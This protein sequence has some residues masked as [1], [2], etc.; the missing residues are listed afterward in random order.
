MFTPSPAPL[1]L[2]LWRDCVSAGGA[3]RVAARSA[4][5]RH[6]PSQRE[7]GKRRTRGWSPLDRQ[8]KAKHHATAGSVVGQNT[9]TMRF[10]NATADG[11]AKPDATAFPRAL[12]AIELLKDALYVTWRYPRSPVGHL[13]G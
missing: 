1:T 3:Q 5:A 7:R 13:N 2:T 4:S 8:R 11:Q 6:S 10:N 9:P 12:G